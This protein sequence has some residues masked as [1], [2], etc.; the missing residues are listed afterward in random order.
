MAIA[1]STTRYNMKLQ[2]AA[3]KRKRNLKLNLD[4]I[5]SI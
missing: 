3:N 5:Y 1:R 2:F 4:Y